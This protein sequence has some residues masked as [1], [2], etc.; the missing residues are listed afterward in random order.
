[1]KVNKLIASAVISAVLLLESWTLKEVVNLKIQVAEL[2]V[3][4]NDLQSK[5]TIARTP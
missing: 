4:I 5:T 1:M 3:R 2:S